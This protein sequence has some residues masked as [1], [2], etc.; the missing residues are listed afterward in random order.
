[1]TFR[2]VTCRGVIDWFRTLR[3]T[4]VNTGGIIITLILSITY[5]ISQCEIVRSEIC[6]SSAFALIFFIND[7]DYYCNGPFWQVLQLQ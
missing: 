5:G 4:R 3:N 1:M 7:L 2:V 6:E